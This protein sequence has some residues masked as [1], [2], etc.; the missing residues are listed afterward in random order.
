[1]LPKISFRSLY[2]FKRETQLFYL[3]GFLKGFG[4]VMVPISGQDMVMPT[5]LGVGGKK[6]NIQ[7]ILMASFLLFSSLCLNG[8]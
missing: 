8:L 1:M 4:H 6:M 5:R 3:N 7:I 2:G